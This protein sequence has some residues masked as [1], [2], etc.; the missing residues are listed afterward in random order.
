MKFTFEDRY[1]VRDKALIFVSLATIALVLAGKA[2]GW[3]GSLGPMF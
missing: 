2:I 1:G 3:H